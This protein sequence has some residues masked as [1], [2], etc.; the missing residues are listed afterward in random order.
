MGWLYSKVERIV[1]QNAGFI[2]NADGWEQLSAHSP[3][4]VTLQRDSGGSKLFLPA[5]HGFLIY[6]YLLVPQGL[7]GCDVEISV[8]WQTLT[9]KGCTV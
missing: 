4:I 6:N 1:P 5:L 8:V 9:L 7:T 3:H 2:V